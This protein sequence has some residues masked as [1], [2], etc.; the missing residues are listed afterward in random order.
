[1]VSDE[2]SARIQKARLAFAFLRHLWRRRDIRL[3]IKGRVYCAA[4]RSVSLWRRRDIRLSIKGRVYCA[5]VRSVLLY[6]RETWQL[7]VEDTRKLLVFDHRC[8]GNIARICWDHRVSNSEARRRVLDDGKSV[9]EVV[10]LHRLRWLDH[11]LRIPGHR[12]PRR[13]MVTGVGD[14]WKKVRGGQTKT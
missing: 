13:A 1:M 12:L 14:G 10:N 4:V 5:A 7:R 11:V 3:S 2:I 6:G 8:L 9:Y